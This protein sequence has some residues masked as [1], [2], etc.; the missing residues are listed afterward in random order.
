MRRAVSVLAMSAPSVRHDAANHVF[1][2]EMASRAPDDCPRVYYHPL[3][4]NRWDFDHT[5]TP[6]ELQGQ[7]LARQVCAAAFA[8]CDEK[9]IDYSQ[10]SCTYVVKLLGE[11]Q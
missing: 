5:M 11:R 6:R 9:G 1:Y 8:F 2:L 3:A 4:E 7:G 10:S